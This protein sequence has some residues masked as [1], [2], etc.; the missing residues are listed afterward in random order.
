M[1]AAA[2]CLLSGPSLARQESTVRIQ[3][4]PIRDVSAQY[5]CR[6]V[7]ARSLKAGQFGPPAVGATWFK[8][9]YNNFNFDILKGTLVV[10]GQ[11]TKWNIV[12]AGTGQDDFV[13][14]LPGRDFVYNVIR[15]RVWQDPVQFIMLD[16]A[17]IFSG[18][19]DALP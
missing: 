2:V 5:R 16:G 11:R 1:C 18:L 4:D 10:A 9:R 3:F 14:N 8:E 6:F 15:I 17:D 7:E 13:A 12:Q 19:C